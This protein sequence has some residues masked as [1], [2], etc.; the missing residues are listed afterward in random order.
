MSEGQSQNRGTLT[1]RQKQC[2]D[3]VYAQQQGREQTVNVAIMGKKWDVRDVNEVDCWQDRHQ[4]Q[5][6]KPQ[7]VRK[8]VL[9]CGF[10]L[11]V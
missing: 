9:V 8:R 2:A 6:L 1:R 5:V 7:C 4:R 11:R 10:L 3:E